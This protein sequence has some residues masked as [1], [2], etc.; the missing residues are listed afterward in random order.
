MTALN[1]SFTEEDTSTWTHER[2]K[3]HVE[4][5]KKKLKSFFTNFFGWTEEEYAEARKV[6]CIEVRKYFDPLKKFPSAGPQAKLR[7]TVEMNLIRDWPDLFVNRHG[8]NPPAWFHAELISRSPSASNLKPFDIKNV[9]Q[10]FISLTRKVVH[11]HGRRV[12]RLKHDGRTEVHVDNDEEDD[13]DDDDGRQVLNKRPRLSWLGDTTPF[14]GITSI[15]LPSPHSTTSSSQANVGAK[16]PDMG[17]NFGRDWGAYSHA[18][19]IP[20]DKKR[21]TNSLGLM[22]YITRVAILDQVLVLERDRFG[23]VDNL[24]ERGRLIEPY[25]QEL[26]F[27]NLLDNKLTFLWFFDDTSVDKPRMIKNRPSAEAAISMLKSRAE[28]A[29]ATGIQIFDAADR[30]TAALV[31]IHEVNR[32]DDFVERVSFELEIDHEND[33]DD[34][35]DSE[36]AEMASRIDSTYES[37]DVELQLDDVAVKEETE[38]KPDI[39][40]AGQQ[41]QQVDGESSS[42]PEED[43]DV[44]RFYK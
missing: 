24:F 39:T 22:L 14:T 5:S 7:H 41:Q 37:R 9:V 25:F 26:I 29:G 21:V 30:D 27:G 33:E 43:E 19:V 15:S 10:Q 44:R 11:K 23:L 3:L 31:P 42:E 38:S 18:T 6:T 8:P 13:D 1:M 40:W 28:R 32:E 17:L 12:R 34:N 36:E 4:D 35:D 16:P 2:V 20:G